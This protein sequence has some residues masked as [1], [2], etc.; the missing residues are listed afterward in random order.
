MSLL[1]KWRKQKSRLESCSHDQCGC[2]EKRSN[3]KKMDRRGAL[4]AM[5]TGAAVATTGAVS[6]A[7][8]FSKFLSGEESFQDFFRKNY[9]EM[10]P[11][12][13]KHAVQRLM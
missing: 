6:N 13:R 9:Q 2:G 10:T 7:S 4:K 12:E 11:E 5:A 8:P 1:A 3:D